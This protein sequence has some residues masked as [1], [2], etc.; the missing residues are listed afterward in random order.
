MPKHGNDA[1]GFKNGFRIGY[2]AHNERLPNSYSY[3]HMHCL[4]SILGISWR[5]KVTNEGV[6]EMTRMPTVTAILKQKRWRW[7][8]HMH[9]MKPSRLPRQTLLEQ[10]A[11]ARRPVCRPK[12]RFKDGV[13]TLF[14]WEK[15]ARERD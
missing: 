3:F 1:L 8:G 4:R 6:L 11:H 12:L 13:S 5:G 9:R 2:F 15:R 14:N 7:L 10:I